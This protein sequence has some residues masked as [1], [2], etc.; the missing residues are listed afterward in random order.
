MLCIFIKKLLAIFYHLL[1][2]LQFW[3]ITALDTKLHPDPRI[4]SPVCIIAVFCVLSGH[5][6]GCY[7]VRQNEELRDP[8]CLAPVSQEHVVVVLQKL[9]RYGQV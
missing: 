9:Q 1:I 5:R 4:H 3:I 6:Q 2:F 8:R 7:S